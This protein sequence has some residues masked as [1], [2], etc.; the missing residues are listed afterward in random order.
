MP[1]VD[2]VVKTDRQNP[3][4]RIQFLGGPNPNGARWKL[5]QPD[6]VEAIEKNTYGEFFV[7]RAGRRVRLIVAVSQWGNKYVKTEA[8]GVQPDNLLAL[9]TC[10]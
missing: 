9:P 1:Q 10:G 4:E 7:D 6:V 2:C 5:S 3:H 8:D